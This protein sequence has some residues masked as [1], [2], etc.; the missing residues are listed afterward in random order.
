MVKFIKNS[1]FNLFIRK[2]DVNNCNLMMERCKRFIANVP[3]LMIKIQSIDETDHNG[4]YLLNNLNIEVWN[5]C[6]SPVEPIIGPLPTEKW[7]FKTVES[8]D[9]SEPKLKTFPDKIDSYLN[10]K[11]IFSPGDTVILGG[12]Y[13]IGRYY[14]FD[15]LNFPTI[16]EEVAILPP[17]LTLNQY[18][19]QQ[20]KKYLQDDLIAICS[21]V[22]RNIALLDAY[23][24]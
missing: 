13:N 17:D 19:I 9:Y 4:L 2:N 3:Y 6:Y 7:Y 1:K 21:F 10:E 11:F 12:E 5:A 20:Y 14:L 8:S 22:K 16:Y 24:Y 23:G 18:I 15:W